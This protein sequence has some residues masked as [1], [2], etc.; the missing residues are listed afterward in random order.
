MVTGDHPRTARAI[1]DD[2]GLRDADD[3]VLTGREIKAL[4]STGTDQD[5]IDQKIGK[6]RVFARVEPRQKLE[7]VDS[8]ARQGHFVAVTGDG[9]NDAPALASAH[10]GVAMG[11]RGT[12]VARESAH[13]ILT[14]DNFASIASG[15]EE[16]RIAYRNIRKVTYLLISTGAAEV[17]MFI[18]AMIAGLPLPL[19][20][21]QLLWL[22][23]VTNGI[24]DV[25]LAFE[26]G[27][28]DEMKQ[29]PRPPKEPI[30]NRIMIERVLVGAVVMGGMAFLLFWNLIQAG[31]EETTARNSVLLLMVLFENVHIGNCRSE[32][33][34]AFGLSPLRNPLLL[35]G[36]IIAQLIHI[37]A[38][39]TPGISSVLETEPVSFMHWIS[40]FALALSVLGAMEIQKF[41]WARRK[42]FPANSVVS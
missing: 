42:N 39:Y 12:D 8:F 18:L 30:F 6:A 25:S 41:L 15:I 10:A 1:A 16:G 38:L 37:A 31:M 27:E 26:P 22:N 14:D 23:L 19:T 11:D 5:E 17:V 33:R 2:L 34:S 3:T 21:V 9:V 7:I 28:G 36:T 32:T 4:T 29:P 20:A 35:F 40:L 13:L 24:Q